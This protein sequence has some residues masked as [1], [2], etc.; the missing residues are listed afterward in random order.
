MAT[1]KPSKGDESAAPAA[2]S[3]L[4]PMTRDEPTKPGGPTSADVHPDQVEAY[5][6]AGWKRA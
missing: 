4:I 6:A 2:E 5:E 1:R 3:G